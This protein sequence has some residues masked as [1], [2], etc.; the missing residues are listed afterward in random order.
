ML[1][2]KREFPNLVDDQLFIDTVG[3]GDSQK[4]QNSITAAVNSAEAENE[5]MLSGEAVPEPSR[6]EDLIAHWDSHRIPMQGREFKLAPDYV[7]DLFERHV[8]ATEKLMFEQATE[9][10]TFAQR[11]TNLRQFPM[12]Y[13]PTPTNEPPPQMGMEGEPE[14]AEELGGVPQQTSAP[15]EG[16]ESP[17]L[18]QGELPPNN[19]GIVEP[20]AQLSPS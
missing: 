2:I 11:L 19:E 14:M 13:T 1:T 17:P 5:D 10:P 15:M 12:F 7:K 4:F 8:T 18:N 16:M 9:S 6:Y 3:I 20:E